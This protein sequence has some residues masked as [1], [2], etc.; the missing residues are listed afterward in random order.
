MNTLRSYL[1]PGP[2]SGPPG[3][4]L[5]MTER[6][7]HEVNCGLCGRL[8]YVDAE[9]FNIVSDLIEAGVDDAFRCEQCKRYADLVY[10]V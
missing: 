9:T 3:P 10:K 2:Q 5:F 6:N 7:Q 8:T 4:T 1:D